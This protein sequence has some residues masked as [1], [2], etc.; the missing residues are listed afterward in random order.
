[1]SPSASAI[2]GRRRPVRDL[3]V[4]HAPGLG[5]PLMPFLPGA[6]PV[7]EVPHP[8]ARG[9]GGPAPGLGPH[10]HA[11]AVGRQRQRQLASFASS[12]RGCSPVWTA[13]MGRKRGPLFVRSD[14]TRR[15]GVIRT[16]ERGGVGPG[17]RLAAACCRGAVRTGEHQIRRSSGA[18]ASREQVRSVVASKIRRAACAAAPPRRPA[19]PPARRSV[20]LA[21]SR[22][23][24]ITTRTGTGTDDNRKGPADRPRH[25]GKPR[26]RQMIISYAQP[27]PPARASPIR[28]IPDP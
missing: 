7:L 23:R 26:A 19:R 10:R 13:I 9:H 25:A 4:E 17:Q 1:M 27:P 11:L 24:R 14:R 2:Q 20:P 8:A 16:E 28:F 18:V 12:D 5:H 6:P 21:P 15:A 3:D 22:P